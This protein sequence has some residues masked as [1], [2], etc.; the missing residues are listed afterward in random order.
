M[1]KIFTRAERAVSNVNGVLGK[2][3]L[4]VDKVAYI[5]SVTFKMYP[6]QQNESMKSAWSNCRGAI[7]EANRRLYRPK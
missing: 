3:Q 5:K 6:L 2:S 7:D 4:D 1:C